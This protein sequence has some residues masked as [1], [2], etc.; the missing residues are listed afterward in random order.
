MSN[1]YWTLFAVR[2]EVAIPPGVMSNLRRALD[3]RRRDGVAIPPGVM[4]NPLPGVGFASATYMLRS[5]Q[6]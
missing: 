4:S 2:G 1:V 5:L 6:G 3:R